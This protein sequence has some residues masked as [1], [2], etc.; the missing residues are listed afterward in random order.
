MEFLNFLAILSAGLLALRR[1]D[2]EEL[3]FRLL[4]ASALFNAFLFFV[5]TR[6]SILPAV[7]F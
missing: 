7:N 5:G 1:P 2:K 6:T 3:A 4:V